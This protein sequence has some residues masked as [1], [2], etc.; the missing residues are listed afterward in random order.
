MN[1]YL[2]IIKT[3]AANIKGGL[4]CYTFRGF[5]P[6]LSVRDITKMNSPVFIKFKYNKIFP[7]KKRLKSLE[8][9]TFMCA[10]QTEAEVKVRTAISDSPT[11]KRVSEMY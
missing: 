5:F 7:S 9:V 2:N 10:L 1:E 4:A 3:Q 11:L 6:L 8:N